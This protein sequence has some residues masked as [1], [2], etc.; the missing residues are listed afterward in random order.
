[1]S[2]KICDVK[3]NYC[4]APL[5]PD[6]ITEAEYNGVTASSHDLM[7]TVMHM[8]V[9]LSPSVWETFCQYVNQGRSFPDIE[10][11]TKFQTIL[12]VHKYHPGAEWEMDTT[13]EWDK[14]VLELLALQTS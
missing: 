14:A 10:K 2:M 3:V 12:F 5:L 9:Y 1:M 7:G 8:Q 4:T 6:K 13:E 11:G